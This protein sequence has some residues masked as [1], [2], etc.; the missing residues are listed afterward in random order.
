MVP[1]NC[2][3]REPKLFN[4]FPGSKNDLIAF[5]DSKVKSGKLSSESALAEI[6]NIIMPRCY[7]NLLL[8]AG[9]EHRNN[10]PRYEELIENLDLKKNFEHCME[11][12]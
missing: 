6:K 1:F 12:A 7:S 5:C 4:F 3:E 11:M 10:I 9:E 8:E 2:S